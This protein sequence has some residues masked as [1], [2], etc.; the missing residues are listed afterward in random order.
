MAL[1]LLLRG[2]RLIDPA[3]GRDAISDIG[4]QHGKIVEIAPVIGGEAALETV[5]VRG[6]LVTAGL[7]DTHAHVYQ[8]VTGKFGLAADL[9]G[10]ES[11]VTT[12]VDQGGPSCM[13][14]G[15]FRKFIAEPART[16]FCA[17]YPPTSSAASKAISIPSS[18]AQG[19]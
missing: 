4:I 7:I 17:S 3:T 18:M 1:D 10:I 5:D 15:G 2:G 8:H 12:V 16:P 9:C 14:I 19:S 11:G 13:T 6:K